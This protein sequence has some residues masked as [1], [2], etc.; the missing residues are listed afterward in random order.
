LK[1]FKKFSK[2]SPK[3]KA[4]IGGSY[5]KRGF[6]LFL[7]NTEIYFFILREKFT[8]G[9]FFLKGGKKYFLL[10]LRKKYIISKEKFLQ[11]NLQFFICRSTVED[12]EK[13]QGRNEHKKLEEQEEGRWDTYPGGQK[14]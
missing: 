7:F 1:K 10:I 14:R 11:K 13:I 8:G 12:R 3:I 4:H 5:Y 2:K 9:E 6:S